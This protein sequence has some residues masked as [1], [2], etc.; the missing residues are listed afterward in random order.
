MFGRFVV[1]PNVEARHAEV[2]DRASERR[3]EVERFP[4]RLDGVFRMARVGQS[5]AKSVPEEE[6]LG[7]CGSETSAFSDPIESGFKTGS[8]HIGSHAECRLEAVLGFLVL[9]VA[10]EQDAESD[11]HVRVDDSEFGRLPRRARSRTGL[12]RREEQI[13]DAVRGVPRRANLSRVERG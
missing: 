3:P 13:D 9:R 4:V 5:R 7:A 8:A 12:R 11:L 2:V 1:A 6:V 10:I